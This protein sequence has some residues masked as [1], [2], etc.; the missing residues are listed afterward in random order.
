MVI[1]EKN[2]TEHKIAICEGKK[3]LLVWNLE[4]LVP[5]TKL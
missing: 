3:E 1:G 2:L 5:T 4:V